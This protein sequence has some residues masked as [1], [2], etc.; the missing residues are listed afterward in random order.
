MHDGIGD[1]V[2]VEAA[3]AKWGD[4]FTNI[5][6]PVD[7]ASAGGFINGN[8]VLFMGSVDRSLLSQAVTVHYIKQVEGKS[9]ECG[10]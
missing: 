2:H 10:E 1:V 5:G 3:G 8:L 6:F 7:Y 4:L 9:V